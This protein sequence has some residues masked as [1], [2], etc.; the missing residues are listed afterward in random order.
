MSSVAD[1][2]RKGDRVVE[3]PAGKAQKPAMGPPAR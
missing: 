3:L 1:R 2:I